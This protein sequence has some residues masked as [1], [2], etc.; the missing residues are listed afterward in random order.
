MMLSFNFVYDFSTN[1]FEFIYTTMVRNA[2]KFT[3]ILCSLFLNVVLL[4][5]I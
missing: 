2:N 1:I 5:T 3:L 4:K